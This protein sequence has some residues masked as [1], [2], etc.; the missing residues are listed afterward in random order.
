MSDNALALI[1]LQLKALN[2]HIYNTVTELYKHLDEL[3]SDLNKECN[4]RQAFKDL[5]MKKGQTFQKFYT[6]FLHYI[7]NGN[8]SAQDLKD[9]L[10]DKLM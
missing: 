6:L 10:N 9:E 3:Y 1:S 7:A 8:I 5:V 2:S 4:A